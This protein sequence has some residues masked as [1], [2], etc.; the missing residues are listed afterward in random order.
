[1]KENNNNPDKKDLLKNSHI[2]LKQ[3][4][5]NNTGQAKTFKEFLDKVSCDCM[6]F[7]NY[8]Y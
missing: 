4:L 2:H 1:M 5:A 3:N 8:F 6:N 7:S